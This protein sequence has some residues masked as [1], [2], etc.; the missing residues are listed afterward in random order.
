M[1]QVVEGIFTENNANWYANYYKRLTK[2]TIEMVSESLLANSKYVERL[3]NFI[4]SGS[5]FH[6]MV[7]L[8]NFN[9]SLKVLCHGDCWT[10]NF[11][12]VYDD[13]N[14]IQETCLVDFQLIRYGSPAM[15]LSNLI[16]CCT[17][18]SLRRNHQTALLQLYH[19]ELIKSMKLLGP[20][21]KDH[22]EEQLWNK[23]DKLTLLLNFILNYFYFEDYNQIG[24]NLPNLG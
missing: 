16:F 6:R 23:Y 13:D 21:P 7:E 24:M 3:K 9:P 17:D 10:N 19:K 2:N 1:N 14:N 8:V 12:Y 11:L 22:D 20:L 4:G 5:F 18:K 15:D